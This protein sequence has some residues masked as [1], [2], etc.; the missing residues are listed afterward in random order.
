MSVCFH[1]MYIYIFIV[2]FCVI[3]YSFF[4]QK[5]KLELTYLKSQLTSEQ[6]KLLQN[7]IKEKDTVFEKE[8][9]NFMQKHIEPVIRQI[10]SGMSPTR[11]Y[12]GGRLDLPK[13][14]EYQLMGFLYNELNRFPLYGR[15]KYK[16]KSDKYEYYVVDESR[17][18]LRIP[19]KTRNDNE[20]FDND[21]IIVPELT[22]SPL[23]TKLYEFETIRYD[24]TVF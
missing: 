12:P 13:Y 6:N 22:G 23:K 5:R 4:E 9:Q 18:K 7:E 8:K 15:P 3:I 24:P 20:L 19:F 10:S 21:E 2:L 14:E 16:G 17:N 1:P 11:L